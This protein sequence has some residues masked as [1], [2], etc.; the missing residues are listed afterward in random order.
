MR[1]YAKFEIVEYS[2]F[3]N[4][5]LSGVCI[6]IKLLLPE[7]YEFNSHTAWAVVPDP[8]KKSSTMSLELYFVTSSII[9]LI[10]ATGFG[11][12]KW[13]L[14]ICF[15]RSCDPDAPMSNQTSLPKRVFFLGT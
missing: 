6:K 15:L 10:K 4:L 9:L 13:Q 5:I 3:L 14:S 12:S 8:A 11:I 7:S 1:W 2:L